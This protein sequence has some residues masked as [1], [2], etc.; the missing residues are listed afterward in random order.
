M[1]TNILLLVL[2]L[3]TTFLVA[4]V[5]VQECK[6]HS[7]EVVLLE[8]VPVDPRDYLRGDY[9][10]LSYKISTVPMALLQR[11]AA[12]PAGTPIFVR[13]EKRGQFDEIESASLTPMP[14]ERGHPVLRG[15]VAGGWFFPGAQNTS[16]GVEYGLERFYV[17]EGTGNPHGKLTVEAAISDAGSAVIKQVYLDGKPYAEAM[18]ER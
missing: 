10:T 9:V 7:G 6:L 3:Q 18:R 13:L 17:H 2:A 12:P 15:K 5:A 11:G 8:T 4:T 14:A 1:K 16:I